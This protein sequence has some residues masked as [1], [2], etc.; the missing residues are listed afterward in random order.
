MSSQD[1]IKKLISKHR[2]RLQKLLEQKAEFGLNTPAEISIE[3]EDIQ[4]EVEQL[5]S[6]L[7]AATGEDAQAQDE[8]PVQTQPISTVEDRAD[9]EFGQK[10][11][12]LLIGNSSFD[13]V[14]TFRHLRT[15]PNDVKDFAQSLQTYGDFET[16]ET[17][18]DAPADQITRAID[19]LF[20]QAEADDL[21]LL[22]YS[23]HGYRGQDGRHYLIAKDTQPKRLLSSG[24]RDTFI[25]E[26]IKNSRA[27]HRVI[28]LDCCFSGA[29][30]A[31]RKSGAGEPL[32]LEE[33]MEEGTAILASS[34][35]I[36]HSF[37]ENC[38]HSLFTHYL[39]RGI[40][41]AP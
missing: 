40:N 2:R 34:N 36:Q 11:L 21:V 16:I 8:A 35:T 33:L 10:R 6:Q 28:I 7:E 29:F 5:Q 39:L 9:L 30:V 24:I 23:G 15:P 12:A 3:I 37:E 27:K 1:D 17:L 20:G 32:L 41:S 13:E 22:Y 19:D 14:Q 4:A 25:H 38:H 18:I 26:A 31:G